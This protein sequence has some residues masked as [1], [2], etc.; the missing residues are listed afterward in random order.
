MRI[1]K[2]VL[3]VSFSIASPILLAHCAAP[4]EPSDSEATGEGEQAAIV[5]PPCSTTL[6]VPT[7]SPSISSALL[8]ICPGGTISVQPGT[9]YGALT[10]A[11]SVTIKSTSTTTLPV[12][13]NTV[14]AGSPAPAAL[15]TISGGVNVSLT[16]LQ[17]KP[18][19]TSGLTATKTTAAPSV[20][21]VG[22][23][24]TGGIES[25]NGVFHSLTAMTSTFT[26]ASSRCINAGSDGLSSSSATIS[27]STVQNCGSTALG[28][29]RFDTAVISDNTVAT[30]Y[31]GINL[32][33]NRDVSI[34]DNF[35]YATRNGIS[36]NGAD[37]GSVN[38]NTVVGGSGI[39]YSVDNLNHL[40]IRRNQSSFS[41]GTGFYLHE[42]A[43][44]DFDSNVVK[45]STYSGVFVVT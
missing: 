35:V 12:I 31:A 21:I 6:T 30:A 8:S 37:S 26:Q 14:V 4:S 18:V 20:T 24:V 25:L 23:W 39:H 42:V 1:S 7:Q 15:I 19:S 17:L 16:N 3:I 13:T 27:N 34:L 38:D 29:A 45:G 32:D 5:L 40:E 41:P 2:L 36:I 43:G 22:S 33:S 9:Y 28:F 44:I 10:I 11:K